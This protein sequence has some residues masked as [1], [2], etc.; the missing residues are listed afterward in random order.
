[1]EENKQAILDALLPALKLTRAGTDIMG[2]HY[3]KDKERVT[4]SYYGSCNDSVNVS[5]DSGIAM[6]IDIAKAVMFW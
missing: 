3:D 2:L 5:C 6:I 4:I 1:M